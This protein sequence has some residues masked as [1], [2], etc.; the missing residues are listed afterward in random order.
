MHTFIL[1]GVL[2]LPFV[3]IWLLIAFL[4]VTIGRETTKR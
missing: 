1:L 4:T 2:A 3:L